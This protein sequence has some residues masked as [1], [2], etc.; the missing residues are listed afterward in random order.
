LAYEATPQSAL[1]LIG[2]LEQVQTDLDAELK[3]L[4]PK[5]QQAA[6][7]PLDALRPR[8][9][10]LPRSEAPAPRAQPVVPG[11]IVGFPAVGQEQAGA[12]RLVAVPAVAKAPIE[13]EW[14]GSWY[15]AE[16]LRVNGRLTQIHYTG[17]DSSWDEWVPAERIRTTGTVRYLQR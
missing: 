8:L 4:P 11:R 1:E 9:A 5:E 10:A 7:G 14:G 13:V 17:Y 6:Q 2:F 15:A 3:A 16:V 12:T